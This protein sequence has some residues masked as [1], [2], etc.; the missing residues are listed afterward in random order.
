[1]TT[2]EPTDT[3]RALREHELKTE[4]PF[5][6]RVVDGS[7]PF[8]VRKDDRGFQPGD[9]LWL[10]EW[11]QD[12]GYTGREARRRVTYLFDLGAPMV[13]APGFVVLGLA[14]DV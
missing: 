7:K 4:P 2:D 11:S 1:M 9:T 3:D 10:R 8:E 5:F 14:D 12:A 6:D 13:N